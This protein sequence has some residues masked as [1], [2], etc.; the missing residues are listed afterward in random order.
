MIGLILCSRVRLHHVPGYRGGTKSLVVNRSDVMQE[1]INR[2]FFLSLPRVCF[3]SPSPSPSSSQQS[4]SASAVFLL[5]L[6]SYTCQRSSHGARCAVACRRESVR[7]LSKA[8]L[9]RRVFSIALTRV[10]IRIKVPLVLE[11]PVSL[12]R[13]RSSLLSPNRLESNL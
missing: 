4:A 13:V 6:A 5:F 7:Y 10:K 9:I 1:S 8:V 2:I 3:L 12:P 11:C